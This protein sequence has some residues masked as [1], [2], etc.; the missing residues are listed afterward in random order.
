MGRLLL[1]ASILAVTLAGSSCAPE[2][3]P[4]TPVPSPCRVDDS[5]QITPDGGR[6]AM[7]CPKDYVAGGN[8]DT[9]CPKGACCPLTNDVGSPPQQPPGAAVKGA[10]PNQGVQQ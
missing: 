5:G 3:P 6:R 7:C 9:S 1:A 4:V 2:P 10:P 8:S